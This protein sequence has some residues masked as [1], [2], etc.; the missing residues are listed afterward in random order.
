MDLRQ[1]LLLSGALVSP[2]PRSPVQVLLHTSLAQNGGPFWRQGGDGRTYKEAT[3]LS[4]Y[5][6]MRVT[7]DATKKNR[8]SSTLV[9]VSPHAAPP[10]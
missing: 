9:P 1:L 7:V 4:G 10:Q 6:R 3:T 2:P 5:E 8:P